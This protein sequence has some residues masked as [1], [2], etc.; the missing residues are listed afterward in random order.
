MALNDK[1]LRI[2][3]E[4]RPDAGSDF[5]LT[6]TDGWPSAPVLETAGQSYPATLSTVTTA[7]DTATWTL[8][9][10]EGA[11]VLGTMSAVVH[12]ITLGLGDAKRIRATG[13]LIRGIAGQGRGSFIGSNQTVVVGPA[14]VSFFPD[15]AHPGLYL[16]A[17]GSGIAPDPDNPGLYLMG[18]LA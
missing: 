7:D 16:M 18:A 10:A 12:N 11:T 15:P 14:A 4:I 1:P 2:D 9:V 17:A 5:V 8:T 3:G 13:Y 6:A